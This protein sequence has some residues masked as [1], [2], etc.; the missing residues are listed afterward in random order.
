MSTCEELN[1]QAQEAWDAAFAL[2]D[3]D[4]TPEK[5]AAINALHEKADALWAKAEI[6]FA[7]DVKEA[8]L[9]GGASRT[10]QEAGA[11]DERLGGDTAAYCS[12]GACGVELWVGDDDDE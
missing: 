7:R 2:G 1:A 4:G 3:Y 11:Q 10:Y 6:A 12:D 9:F 8:V 5:T